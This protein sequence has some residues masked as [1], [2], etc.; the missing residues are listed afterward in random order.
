MLRASQTCQVW[1]AI[2]DLDR[3][4]VALKALHDKFCRDK[5]QI[6]AL[7]HEYDVGH[8]FD[9]P[10]VIHIYEYNIHRNIPYITME[11]GISR[12]MKM[13]LR[14]DGENLAY[15]TPKIISDAAKGLGYI[16]KLGWIHRD[17][18]PDNFL[19][20]YE[21]NVKLIDFS[22]A[23]KKRSGLSKWFGGSKVQ[24]TRSYMSPE[25]IKGEA[26]DGRADL[27]SFGCSIFELMSGKLPYTATSAD[28]LLDKHIRGPIPTL[29][30]ANPNVTDEFSTL[31]ARMM[32]KKK[33]DRPD[34]M[35]TLLRLF[36]TTKIYKIPPKKPPALA[37]QDRKALEE[38]PPVEE[39][40][41]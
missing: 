27:Y 22:I 1:E 12:N 33:E 2:N 19:L 21:G 10:L 9:H 24:G 26:L 16:H 39:E 29:L 11:C 28:H 8:H 6:Q 31:V 23:E 40:T 41:K 20:D 38:I 7:K 17:V 4:R 34:D 5:E 35:D 30:A 37:E 18:K 32:A 15:W 13:A 25:Q 36:Q 3:R 14:E